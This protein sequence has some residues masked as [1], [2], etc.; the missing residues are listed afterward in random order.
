M[1]KTV[2]EMTLNRIAQR[3]MHTAARVTLLEVTHEKAALNSLT[4]HFRLL[5]PPFQSSDA[6]R[7]EGRPDG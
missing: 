4:H 2:T 6:S 1:P 7:C 5:Q 3:R